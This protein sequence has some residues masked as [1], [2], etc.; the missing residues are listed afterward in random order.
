MLWRKER[1][2]IGNSAFHCGRTGL[3]ANDDRMRWRPSL[4]LTKTVFLSVGNV[5]SGYAI[6]CSIIC[7]MAFAKCGKIGSGGRRSGFQML[8]GKNAAN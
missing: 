6:V 4:V 8:I 5:F 3:G 7:L 1:I 2:S